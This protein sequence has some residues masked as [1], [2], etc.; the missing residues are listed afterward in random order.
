VFSAERHKLPA[1]WDLPGYGS[2]PVVD[3]DLTDVRFFDPSSV[4]VGL[5][6]KGRAKRDETGFVRNPN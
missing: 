4:I 5:S 2:V 1:T 6:A 3:G